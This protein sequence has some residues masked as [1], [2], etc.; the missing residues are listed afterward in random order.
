MTL[1]FA[2]APPALVDA[3]AESI[4]AGAL[5]ASGLALEIGV[6]LIADG[7][8]AAWFAT[9]GAMHCGAR[10]SCGDNARR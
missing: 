1:G 5:L 8:V 10:R 9:N 6:R 7:T 4:R 2:L 3:I